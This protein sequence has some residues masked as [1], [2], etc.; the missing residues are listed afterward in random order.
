MGNSMI[1]I[2]QIESQ[3]SEPASDKGAKECHSLS[4]GDVAFVPSFVKMLGPTYEFD[5]AKADQEM[6][7]NIRGPMQLVKA[8]LLRFN[9]LSDG[10][11]IMSIS[12]IL[13]L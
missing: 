9:S 10:V 6:D 12:S 7:I 3:L 8:L 2:G 13:S 11:V 1:M 4:T 5:L